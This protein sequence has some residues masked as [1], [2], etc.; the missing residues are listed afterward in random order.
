MD[1]MVAF[2]N[3]WL[4]ES[5]V[6]SFNKLDQDDLW[7][8][9]EVY[10]AELPDGVRYLTAGVDTQDDRLE[11]SVYGHGADHEC[12][13]I[14][15]H[16]I[17]GDTTSEE[18]PVWTQ[19]DVFLNREFYYT[20]RAKLPI[21]RAFVD[22]GGHSTSSVY[23]FTERKGYRI[24]PSKGASV[25]GAASIKAITKTSQTRQPLVILGTDT[26]KEELL[27]RLSVKEHGPGFVHYPKLA[28]GG[29]AQ[30]FDED[31]FVA[32]SNEAPQSRLVNGVRKVSWQKIQ[33]HLPNEAWDCFV[34]AK[35]ALVFS[36]NQNLDLNNLEKPKSG[37]KPA[38]LPQ[39]GTMNPDPRGNRIPPTEPEPGKTLP[40]WRDNRPAR[41]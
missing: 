30:G 31:F 38:P 29:V 9:R 2:K 20:D 1:Q 5:F 36:E 7:K 40:R 16:R 27:V 8:R 4:G 35:A 3:T 37:A 11:V 26:L 41:L 34:Y 14:V 18:S 23:K 15:H 24:M 22:S 6:E 25:Q 17:Y 33:S 13:G 32:I 10:D 39:W 19:L 28:D 12:W 21:S